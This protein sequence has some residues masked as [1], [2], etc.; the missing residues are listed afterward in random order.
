M[1]RELA[2]M[3]VGA[4]ELETTPDSIQPTEALFGDGLGLDSIDALEMSLEIAKRYGVEIR[5]EHEHNDQIFA[6]L[7]ALAA[8]VDQHK[9]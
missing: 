9:K 7:S 1:E 5:A 6:S 2:V 3:I 8:Y 4:L